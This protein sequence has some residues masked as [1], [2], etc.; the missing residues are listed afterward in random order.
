MSRLVGSEV[1]RKR[2]GTWCCLFALKRAGKGEW[3]GATALTGTQ[4]A[5][6]SDAGCFEKAQI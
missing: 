2:P 4:V 5:W 1:S 6:A 3:D